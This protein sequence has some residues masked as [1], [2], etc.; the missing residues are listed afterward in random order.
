MHTKTHPSPYLSRKERKKERK[1]EEYPFPSF[2]FLL[3]VADAEG[4]DD[5]GDAGLQRAE[6]AA[7][8]LHILPDGL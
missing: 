3:S 5:G 7:D 2:L 8:R 6:L 4:L 1:K